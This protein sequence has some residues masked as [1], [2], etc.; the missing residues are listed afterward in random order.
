MI[1]EEIRN[2]KSG[3]KELRKF[4][5]TMGVVLMLLGGF[6]WWRE[7]EYYFWFLIPSALF[8]FLALIVPVALKPINKIWMTLAVLMSWVMTRVLLGILFYLG[9]TPMSFFARLF[10]KDFLDIKFDKNVNSY[11][12]LTEKRRIEKSDYE[13]QF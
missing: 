9:I 4:G 1:R 8:V 10:G 5:I 3:K 13:K 7:K 6:S 2:I 11:W 12:I